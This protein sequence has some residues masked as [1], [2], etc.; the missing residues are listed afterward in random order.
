MRQHH[1]VAI[2]GPRNTGK[3]RICKELKQSLE[4]EV[5]NMR[6][7]ERRYKAKAGMK[8]KVAYI[9][10]TREDNP[11]DLVTHAIASPSANILV[12][13]NEKVDPLFET[14]IKTVLKV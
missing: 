9:K 6:E 14:K 7:V 8:W 3:S 10:L 4:A 2:S 12:G 1:F 11:F 13:S 5:K